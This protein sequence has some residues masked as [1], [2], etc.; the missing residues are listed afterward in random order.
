MPAVTPETVQLL[1]IVGG[2]FSTLAAVALTHYFTA[3]SETR[4]IS[5]EDRRRWHDQRYRTVS[6]LIAMS[7]KVDRRLLELGNV[8]MVLREYPE[9]HLRD[10]RAQFPV[11]SY[12]TTD[13]DDL[14]ISDDELPEVRSM[15]RGLLRVSHDLEEAHR[16]VVDLSV[17]ASG[18]VVDRAWATVQGYVDSMVAMEQLSEYDKAMDHLIQARKEQK[19]LVNEA[20]RLLG[21]DV[22]LDLE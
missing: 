18:P 15:V 8:L 4:R 22:E 20:R 2:L 6:D 21:A 9:E 19:E 16:L 11:E 7:F 12:M 13:E 17:V 10:W 5:A 3:R 14:L 1:T